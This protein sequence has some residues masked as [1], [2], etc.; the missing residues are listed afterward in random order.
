MKP[1]NHEVQELL[2][3]IEEALLEE[4]RQLKKEYDQIV[5]ETEEDFYK[6]DGAPR[7]KKFIE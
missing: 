1:Q 2:E 7:G 5:R 6:F 3:S 4:K